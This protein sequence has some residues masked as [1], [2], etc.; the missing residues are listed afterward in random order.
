MRIARALV[1]QCC[2]L[3]VGFHGTPVAALAVVAET[4]E[5]AETAGTAADAAGDMTIV[6]AAIA[7]V[8][9]VLADMWLVF[10]L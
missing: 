2:R 8:T 10:A 7:P 6:A 5:T 9:A 4:A 1:H 3:L